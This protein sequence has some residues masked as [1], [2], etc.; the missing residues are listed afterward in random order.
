MVFPDIKTWLLETVSRRAIK[1]LCIFQEE[2]RPRSLFFRCLN[3]YSFE[4]PTYLSEEI[5]RSVAYDEIICT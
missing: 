2:L 3:V 4:G 1:V 5:V